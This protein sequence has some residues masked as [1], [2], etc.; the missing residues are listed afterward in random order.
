MEQKVWY[1][2]KLLTVPE[3]RAAQARVKE[4]FLRLRSE[5]RSWLTQ[6]WLSEHVGLSREYV[7]RV[8]NGSEPVPRIAMALLFISELLCEV[9]A[10]MYDAEGQEVAA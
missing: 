10:G 5:G 6:A 9:A 1:R 7:S 8:L 3:Y 4:D 2:G